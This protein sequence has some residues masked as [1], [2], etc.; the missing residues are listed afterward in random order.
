LSYR[1]R[2]EE[3]T[4]AGLRRIAREQVANAVARFDD[5]ENP[6]P[7]QVHALRTTCKKMRAMLQLVG[8]AGGDAEQ[9]FR[10][11]ARSVSAIRDQHVQ[12]DWLGDDGEKPVPIN[13]RDRLAVQ[14]AIAQIQAGLAA[15][16][17]PPPDTQGLACLQGG[18]RATLSRCQEALRRA[19]E[20]PLDHR[21]H[22]LRKWTKYHWY[23]LR[24]LR[25][26]RPELENR[27]SAMKDISEDLGLAQDYA[28][29]E[30]QMSEREDS[31]P[32]ALV[33]LHKR[34]KK[35]QKRSRK[36][37]DHWFEKPVSLGAGTPDN[38]DTGQCSLSA[39]V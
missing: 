1:L 28:V 24:L 26:L 3:R 18:F 25:S 35:L 12:A 14:Q 23:Q 38:S 4:G 11:A 17:L 20:R 29:L 39:S 33:E 31:D 21:Y 27:L 36:A 7:D 9:H 10:D 16:S 22:R 8:T 32:V 13:E 37:C 2:P 19:E 6:F 5:P 34:K 30:A 15:M